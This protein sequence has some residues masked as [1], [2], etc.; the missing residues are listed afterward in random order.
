MYPVYARF[1][2]L[3][4]RREPRIE[5]REAV[6]S[7]LGA[8]SSPS[9]LDA[10]RSNTIALKFE[11][12]HLGERFSVMDRTTRSGDDYDSWATA[13]LRR[14]LVVNRRFRDSGE[15]GETLDESQSVFTQVS[16][17]RFV[18][19]MAIAQL[20]SLTVVRT[21]TSPTTLN[22]TKVTGNSVVFHL[23][24]SWQGDLLWSGEPV[25]KPTLLYHR[26][27]DEFVRRGTNLYGFAF[28]W[29]CDRVDRDL[30]ALSGLDVDEVHVRSGQLPTRPATI[31][32][33][34][35]ALGRLFGSVCELAD[36]KQ[37]LAAHR[38]ARRV[39]Q[40]A[41]R[42]MLSVIESRGRVADRGLRDP[43]RIVLLAEEY[44]EQAGLQPVSLAELCRAAGVSARKL[45]YAFECV[46]GLPP[47]KYFKL[48]RLSAARSALRASSPDR[49][50][51][52]IAAIEAGYLHF[53][54]FASDYRSL[55]GET[56][57]EPLTARTP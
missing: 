1:R 39:S 17:G 27:G 37:N 34:G 21:A 45:Q 8:R 30:A 28:G 31:R 42:S 40:I 9:V 43:S 55:F 24:I 16:A 4:E 14:P 11:E 22:A 53:G 20:G 12:P 36:R 47:T 13:A 49:G 3:E 15:L 51:V 19:E 18:G 41:L 57:S 29:D 10:L 54:R 6:D 48:R 44:F 52:K 5:R 7:R 35:Q 23:P 2:S 25:R 38:T 33:L 46:C 32:A 26:P 56:P 50:A